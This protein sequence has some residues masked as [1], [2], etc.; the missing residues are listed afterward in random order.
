MRTAIR[1]VAMGIAT[2]L[3]L[4][5]AHAAEP[6]YPD[7]PIR[8]II[9]TPAGA[10]PDIVGR[11]LAERLWKAWGQRVVVDNRPGA[12][13]SISA[14][15]TTGY[16]HPV[17]G[18][19]MDFGALMQQ[20]PCQLHIKT[21]TPFC[22]AGGTGPPGISWHNLATTLGLRDREAEKKLH[23]PPEKPSCE[24]ARRVALHGGILRPGPHRVDSAG[25]A[26]G[27]QSTKPRRFPR[28][29]GTICI[30]KSHV[31]VHR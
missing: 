30:H 24:G 1:L 18:N 23:Q 27:N 31:G 12:V 17:H 9:G 20:M 21:K 28:G 16:F 13:G 8:L 10:G 11:V 6:V 3:G 26:M 2:G 15:L 5:V 22:E 14:E 25:R 19:R 4:P 7:R 29:N